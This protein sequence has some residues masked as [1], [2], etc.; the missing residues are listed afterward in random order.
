[1][2]HVDI[3]DDTTDDGIRCMKAILWIS[4]LSKEEVHWMPTCGGFG[5]YALK[6]GRWEDMVKRG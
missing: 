3:Q 2:T 4:P 5:F 1:M 6:N